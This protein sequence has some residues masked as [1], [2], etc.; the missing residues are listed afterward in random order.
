MAAADPKLNAQEKQ[1]VLAV[2]GA[3]RKRL[4]AVAPLANHVTAVVYYDDNLR[5]LQKKLNPRGYY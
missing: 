1:L 5:K 3:E 2:F 4:K